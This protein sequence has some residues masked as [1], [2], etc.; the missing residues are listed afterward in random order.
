MTKALD[1]GKLLNSSG[2]VPSAGIA[3]AA[4]TTPKI[5]D[6]AVVAADIANGAVTADKIASNAVT[7]TKLAAGV[8]G[9]VLQAKQSAITNS[10]QVSGTYGSDIVSV[11]ITPS[12][13]SS[14]ILVV[15]SMSFG[16]DGGGNYDTIFA[17]HR[18][19]SAISAAIGDASGGSTRGTFSGAHRNQYELNN[20]STTYLDS[21]ATTSAITY[22]IRVRTSGTI[23]IN[24]TQYR[25][26]SAD[27]ERGI[28]T[29]TVM[30]VAA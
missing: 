2:Q 28:S 17:L 29:I 5:A 22:S 1:L 10:F 18:N 24:S 7:S 19:G 26:T 15:A 21:P 16:T 14:K 20:G 12:S 8:G 9:K 11:S 4:I 30:E 3:D 23:W 13:A 27:D 6:G 25:P